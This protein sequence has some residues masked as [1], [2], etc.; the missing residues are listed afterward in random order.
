[1]PAEPMGEGTP[2]ETETPAEP[3]AGQPMPGGQAPPATPPRGGPPG[4]GRGFGGGGFGGGGARPVPAGTYR[5][6]LTVDGQEFTQTVRIVTD[7]N[8]PDDAIGLEAWEEVEEEK[9]EERE[10]KEQYGP[11]DG[12]DD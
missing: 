11:A 12:I 2:T 8:A 1:M 9:E 5:V 4:G 10:R 3:T 7:P 6:V